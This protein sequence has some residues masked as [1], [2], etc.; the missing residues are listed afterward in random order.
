[1]VKICLKYFFLAILWMK[2]VLFYLHAFTC[3]ST[4][5]FNPRASISYR[6]FIRLK[7]GLVVELVK[8]L[9]KYVIQNAHEIQYC[10]II[11]KCD[12]RCFIILFP[13]LVYQHKTLRHLPKSYR[14]N[15]S[16]NNEIG[17]GGLAGNV[18]FW[19]LKTYD[20]GQCW[21]C[22]HKQVT[23]E[24]LKIIYLYFL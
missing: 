21:L 14:S 23:T 12:K 8:T 9:S 10:W 16:N 15:V 4:F 19:K 2:S 22:V 3:I 17:E 20:W 7:P 24:L 13:Q 5:L 11:K 1:M 18:A 6:F